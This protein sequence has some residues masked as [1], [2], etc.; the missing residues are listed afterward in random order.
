MSKKQDTVWNAQPHTLAK[1]AILQSYL[2]KWF[3]ILGSTFIRKNLW[4][5]DGF[6][7]PGEYRGGH[8]GSPIAAIKA[9]AQALTL[10]GA[11]WKARDIRCVFIEE[12]A[13][14]FANLQTCLTRLQEHTCVRVQPF[15]G[16][17]DER[18]ETLKA[19][20]N[21]PF[22]AD[23]PIFAFIDP[24]GATDVPFKTVQDLLSHPRT[25]VL[26]NL[27]SDGI[28]RIFN[29]GAH[30]DHE[31]VLSEIFGGD[32]W[33]ALGRIKKM[34]ERVQAIVN[35][36]KAKLR[37]ILG[38]RYV[39][40]FEMQSSSGSINYHLVFASQHSLGLEKM[41]ESMKQLDQRGDYRFCDQHVGQER[42]FRFDDAY[43]HAR[44]MHD[45]FRGKVVDYREANDYALNESPFVN[46]KAMLK[47]L[48]RRQLIEVLASDQ[49]RKGTYPE[50]M[51][52]SIRFPEDVPSG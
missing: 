9:A 16:T 43:S 15:Q 18:L 14:R 11:R 44:A 30:A 39:F 20:L 49:R 12:D 21:G 50:H 2:Q 4:Y 19:D 10:S 51:R 29:A 45:A 17:F 26:L 25:E 36:Y 23:E 13:A 24:F 52:L 42:L 6:A 37:A 48:E 47:E 1:V 31:R 7:G 33:K 38:V 41:K 40:S 35:L 8:D 46:A 28:D 22:R 34:Q 3:S 27:D 5:I 32:D